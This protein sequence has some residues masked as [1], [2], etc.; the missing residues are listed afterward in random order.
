M[1]KITMGAVAICMAIAAT[2]VAAHAAACAGNTM[3]KAED[4]MENMSDLNPAKPT[5]AAELATAS[6]ALS[7]GD[8]RGCA[9]HLTKATH[10][11]GMKSGM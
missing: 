6:T 2:P 3:T 9:A 10:L 8:A 5:I 7:N 11:E 4:M 1:M